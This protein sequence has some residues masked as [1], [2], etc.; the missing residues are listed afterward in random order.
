MKIVNEYP[1]NYKSINPPKE[2]KPVFAYGDIIYNPH[3]LTIPED[4]LHHEQ[5]HSKQQRSY[6]SPQLWWSRYLIDKIFRQEQEVEAFAAQLNFIRAEIPKAVKEALDEYAG[7][8]SSPL[9]NLGITK[10]QAET[11][12]RLKAK[13]LCH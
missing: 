5:V 7:Q 3:N 8:L 4:V 10:Y 9:Y 11:L 13:E 6:T 1:P 12:I 2:F